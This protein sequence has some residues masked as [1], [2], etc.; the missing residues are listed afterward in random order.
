MLLYT[1]TLRFR[2]Q[3]NYDDAELLYEL[4]TATLEDA[5]LPQHE[6]FTTSLGRWAAL[7]HKQVR[8]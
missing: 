6:S 3:G 1:V 4:A 5:L 7:L 2:V 8:L